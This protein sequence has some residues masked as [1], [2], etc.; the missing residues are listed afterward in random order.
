LR[1]SAKKHPLFSLNQVHGQWRT[2]AA[3]THD[4]D[5]VG[6]GAGY[7]GIATISPETIIPLFQ[8]SNI[9]IAREA[10]KVRYPD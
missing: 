4:D 1:I 3:G 10:H 8:Y 2:P 9:P 6:A 5:I 7:R